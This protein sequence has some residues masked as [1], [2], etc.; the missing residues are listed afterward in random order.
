MYDEFERAMTGRRPAKL[1]VLGWL[2][3]GFVL[4]VLVGILV[5][6]FVMNRAVHQARDFAERF[7]ASA[8]FAELAEL[9][10]LGELAG[11][12]GLEALGELDSPIGLV[13]MD[14][15]QGLDY[16]RGLQGDNP[17]GALLRRVMRGTFDRGSLGPLPALPPAVPDAPPEGR[18]LSV[19]SE[20]GSVRIDLQ[21]TGSGGSLTIGSDDGDVRFDLVKAED[22]GQLVIRTD[23]ETVRIGVGDAAQ[24]MPSWVPRFEGLPERPHP[25]YS[26]ES[27]EGLLGAVSWS[28]EAAAA[29]VLSF[30]RSELEAQ[31]YDVRD[32]ARL[33]GDGVEE[34]AFWARSESDERVVF[35]VAHQEDGEVTVLL[36]YGEERL[37]WAPRVGPPARVVFFLFF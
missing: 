32:E 37:G 10:E 15:D 20:D 25:V 23:D 36:G 12:A 13:S 16:L 29:D 24:A 2:V 14:P 22:G 34:G 5:V 28:G 4:V 27:S 21:R 26:L 11:L 6:G 17:A 18:S 8:E 30:Y 1:S 31:G 19:H 33:L 9:G 3:S 7:E 35:V